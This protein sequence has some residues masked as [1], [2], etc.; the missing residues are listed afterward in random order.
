MSVP[1]VRLGSVADVVR[2]GVDP[3]VAPPSTR[4]V[5]LEHIASNGQFSQVAAVDA[6]EL[7]STKFAF[8]D[9][10]VLFGKLRPYLR[11]VARPEFS[12]ICSTDIVPIAPS[13]QLDRNYLFQWL[14]TDAVIGKATSMAS[15]A[16]LPRISPKHLLEF[17]LPLP[18]LDEQRRIAAILDDADAL[19]RRRRGSRQLVMQFLHSTFATLF[20][21]AD[22]NRRQW[23]IVAVGEVADCIVPG[24]DKPKGF[25][26]GTP[27]VT[28]S[29]LI[30]LGD[31]CGSSSGIG[32]SD[33]EIEAAAA[34]VIP[35]DSVIIT[36][37][38]DL[39]I[40]SI[41]RQRM[42]INQQ[43]HA[44]QVRSSL[45]PE[46]LCF[47]L[48][49]K[50]LYMERMSSSTT[51]PY[52]NKSVCNGIPIM[53]PDLEIQQNFSSAYIRASACIHAMRQ[54]EQRLNDLFTALQHRAFSGEL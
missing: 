49:Y 7:A 5:G 52:M 38:G 32:L 45:T 47:A 22:E 36:C 37:V 43:L 1:R 40:S 13:E 44:F 30:H 25:S 23:P 18:P 29:D 14:R 2:E 26:G 51:L 17:E 21:D 20:G 48:S 28:T 19:R 16:N 50:K 3:R 42:V 41:A 9:R 10:H 4:Y 27:W 15:G 24:R 31:T 11:K 33:A 35:N 34:R 6:S 8:T 39:G 54:H 12:G 46:Y 53:L